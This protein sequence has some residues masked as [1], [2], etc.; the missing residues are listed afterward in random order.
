MKNILEELSKNGESRECE[1]EGRNMHR[2][3]SMFVR[4]FSQKSFKYKRSN[5]GTDQEAQMA[6]EG[7]IEIK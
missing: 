1:A 5:T 2:S 7:D 6:N 4:I 3:K